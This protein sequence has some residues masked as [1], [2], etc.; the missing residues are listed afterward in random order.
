MIQYECARCGRGYV[1]PR[2][3]Q[4]AGAKGDLSAF[5]GRGAVRAEA[6]R[7]ELVREDDE[8]YQLYTQSLHF[9]TGCRQFVCHE[10]WARI[11]GICLTCETGVVGAPRHVVPVA[12]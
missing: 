5:K 1:P 7:L 4:N 3:R 10:C 8:A 2:P 11:G 9:C 12:P 6:R